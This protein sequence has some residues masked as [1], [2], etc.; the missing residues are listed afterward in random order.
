MNNESYVTQAIIN[1]WE[2]KIG[3]MIGR[4]M[5]PEDFDN[6]RKAI[7]AFKVFMKTLIPCE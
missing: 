1:L 2:F 5:T 6:C 3:Q 7:E 4:A